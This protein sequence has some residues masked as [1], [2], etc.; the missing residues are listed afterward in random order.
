[1]LLFISPNKSL[2]EYLHFSRSGGIWRT[3]NV[4][5]LSF[6]RLCQRIFQM[7]PL[8][9]V[10]AMRVLVDAWHCEASVWVFSCMK[11]RTL[12][13][14]LW[15]CPGDVNEVDTTTHWSLVCLHTASSFYWP[16]SYRFL[17]ITYIFWV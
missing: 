16:V 1:M 17:E 3:Y 4:F 14:L 6:S 13:W 9:F 5:I 7:Y 15:H 2:E 8:V 11:H 10:P 12:L